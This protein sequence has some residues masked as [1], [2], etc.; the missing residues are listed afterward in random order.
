MA[1]GSVRKIDT[2]YFDTAIKELTNAI[3][4]FHNAKS[5]IDNATRRLQDTW[6]GKGSK[7]FDDAYKRL[8][9]ELDDQGENL[10]AMRDDLQSILETYREWDSQN[11]TNIS[12]NSI[13]KS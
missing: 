5:N 11:A 2:V 6:D 3:S 7:K 12:G 10:V 4:V 9:R 8:K 13:S 1:K